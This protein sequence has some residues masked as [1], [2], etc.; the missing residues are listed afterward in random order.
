MRVPNESIK[1]TTDSD[2]ERVELSRLQ[3]RTGSFVWLCYFWTHSIME[4][5]N[6]DGGRIRAALEELTTS[7]SA[8]R[9]IIKGIK[10]KSVFLL[11]II[12]EFHFLLH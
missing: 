6:L 4:D 7:F 10:E 8:V 2:L 11:S 3:F 12:P 1:V 9:K 5:S